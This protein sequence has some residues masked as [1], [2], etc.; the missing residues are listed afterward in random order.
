[1]EYSLEDPP[2]ESSAVVAEQ[3]E[4]IL[5]AVNL[6]ALVK[7]LTNVSTFVQMASL[8][9]TGAGHTE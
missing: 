6:D 2:P 5:S 7:G 3:K 9:V 8:G 4:N 1:M